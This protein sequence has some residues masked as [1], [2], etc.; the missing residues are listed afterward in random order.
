[1]NISLTYGQ[2]P[3]R[4]LKT[5]LIG[6]VVKKLLIGCAACA[7]HAEFKVSRNSPNR[8]ETVLSC[9][10]YSLVYSTLEKSMPLSPLLPGR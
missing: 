4:L 10:D 5:V 2:M 9:D 7:E 3:D 6:G 1:M 8:R